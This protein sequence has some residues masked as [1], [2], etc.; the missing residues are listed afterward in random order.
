MSLLDALKAR[1]QWKP[2]LAGRQGGAHENCGAELEGL[3]AGLEVCVYSKLGVMRI[4]DG[5]EENCDCC[6]GDGWG[7]NRRTKGLRTKY[8]VA[9]IDE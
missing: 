2:I 7:V 4:H 3:Y 1:C 8:M 9:G 5:I 6:Y